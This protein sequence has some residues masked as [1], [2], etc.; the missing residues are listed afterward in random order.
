MHILEQIIEAKLLFG[1]EICTR[2]WWSYNIKQVEVEV[3]LHNL[4]L[5]GVD[6]DQLWVVEAENT[7]RVYQ[8]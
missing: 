1:F 8:R 7:G 3:V 2:W 4:E 6:L 5:L